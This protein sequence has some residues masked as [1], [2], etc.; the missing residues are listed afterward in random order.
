MPSTAYPVPADAAAHSDT[1]TAAEP[2]LPGNR[3]VTGLTASGRLHLGNYLGAIRPL[4]QLA[5]DPANQALVLVAES[6]APST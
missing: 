1:T 6:R 3:V 4:L 5:E 2:A